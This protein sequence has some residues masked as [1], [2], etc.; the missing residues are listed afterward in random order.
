MKLPTCTTR[1][2]RGRFT[3]ALELLVLA[4]VQV[5]ARWRRAALALVFRPCGIASIGVLGG[6]AHPQ[7]RDL[8]DLH[9]RIDRDWQVR[10]I[11]E[12]ERE[13]AAEARINK[14][15]RAVDQQ[16]EAAEARLPLQSSNQVVAQRYPLSR[17]SE[18]E[19]PGVEDEGFP[20]VD[21]DEL[22]QVVLRLLRVDVRRRVVAEDPEVAVDV[23]ID[24]RRLDRVVRQRLDHDPPALELLA[25]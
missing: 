3:G 22:R 14:S 2:G 8:A 13:M 1:A 23:K 18:D 15:R 9:P 24:R 17:R 4:E 11:R 19:L 21:L 10:D 16:P 25:D 20:V 5:V 12:L 6:G 7:K